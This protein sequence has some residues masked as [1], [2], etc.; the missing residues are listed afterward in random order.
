[1]KHKIKIKYKDL[2]SFVLGETDIDPIES[3][4]GKRYEVMDF[5]IYDHK[6]KRCVKQSEK[7]KEFCEEIT[8]IRNCDLTIEQKKMLCYALIETSP[9]E[10]NL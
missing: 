10:V 9:T 2:E 8:L 3:I 1:M 5:G 6:L 7:Y 4:I